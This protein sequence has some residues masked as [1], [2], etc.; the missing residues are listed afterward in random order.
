LVRAPDGRCLKTVSVGRHSSCQVPATYPPM[1]RHPPDAPLTRAP[2]T[3]AP[4]QHSPRASPRP[5]E[6]AKKAENVTVP[7]VVG[8]GG[9]EPPNTGSKVPRLT[10]W[11]RP[12][13]SPEASNKKISLAELSF[14]RNRP[15]P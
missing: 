5:L 4:A 12:S 14:P 10:A 13:R 6:S 15:A 8:A 11:P 3:H 1:V 9:F 7:C 2:A